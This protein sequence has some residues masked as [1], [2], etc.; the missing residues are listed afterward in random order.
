MSSAAGEINPSRRSF[1]PADSIHH[2]M[3]IIRPMVSV[4]THIVREKQVHL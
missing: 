2:I 4:S 1:Y 3:V